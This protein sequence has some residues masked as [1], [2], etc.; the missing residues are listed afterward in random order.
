[1]CLSGRDLET[2]LEIREIARIVKEL[3]V[4]FGEKLE[5]GRESCG[6]RGRVTSYWTELMGSAY[7][8]LACGT[9]SFEELMQLQI[10]D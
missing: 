10:T 9:E 4:K 5:V 7:V 8:R 3:L 1:M 6:A 2:Q